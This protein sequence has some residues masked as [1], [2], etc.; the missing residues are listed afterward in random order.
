MYES[1]LM[2]EKHKGLIVFM[3]V[4]LLQTQKGLVLCMKMYLLQNIRKARH[5]YD[6]E[7]IA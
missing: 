7:L 4:N 5:V 6:S 3:I 2:A 1:V